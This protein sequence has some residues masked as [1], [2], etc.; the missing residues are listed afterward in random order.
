MNLIILTADGKTTKVRNLKA[1]RLCFQV[2]LEDDPENVR[3]LSPI[4]ST[5][6][7][8]SR[9]M[10]D[11]QIIRMSQCHS[12]V[13]GGQEVIMLCEKVFILIRNSID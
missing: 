9:S 3:A 4:L 10:I 11:L 5:P 1:V 6:I 2:F 8:D 12:P 7:F 13:G